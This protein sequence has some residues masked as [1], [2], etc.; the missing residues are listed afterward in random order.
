MAPEN[1]MVELDRGVHAYLQMPGSLGRS[2]SGLIVGDR[3]AVVVDALFTEKQTDALLARV[4]AVTD[5]PVRYLLLTHHHGDHCFGSHRIPGATLVAHRRC[6]EEMRRKTTLDFASRTERL[7]WLDFAGARY[8]YPDVTFD[9]ELTVHLGDREVR[10]LHYG[11]AHTTGDAFAY[12]PDERVVFCGDLLFYKVTPFLVEG[13]FPGWLD[14]L[15]RLLALDARAYVPGHGPVADRDGV[16]ELRDYI[17]LVYEEGKQAF[18]A[19]LPVREA[20]ER[21]SLGAFARWEESERLLLNVSRLYREL[22][23]ESPSTPLDFPAIVDD[24][25]RC[26]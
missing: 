25:A 9:R 4:R 3:D 20:A 23:G 16:R 10:F 21:I 22:S 15:D 1:L 11:T 24:L 26:C 6:H 8:T 13:S 7:P 19:G 14:V 2:N 18:A 5:K 12:L 17:A